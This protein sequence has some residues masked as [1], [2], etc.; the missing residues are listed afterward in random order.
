MVLDESQKRIYQLLT[1]INEE[2]IVQHA[3]LGETTIGGNSLIRAMGE[4]VEGMDITDIRDISTDSDVRD[5]LITMI[6]N[7]VPVASVLYH[8]WHE[9]YVDDQNLKWVLLQRASHDTVDYKQLCA[10]MDNK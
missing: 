1:T 5:E 8:M 9:H 2:S 6:S 7:N 4:L 10:K 3:T